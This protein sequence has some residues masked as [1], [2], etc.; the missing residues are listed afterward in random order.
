MSQMIQA[1]GSTFWCV[2]DACPR[3]AHCKRKGMCCRA[4]RRKDESP[5]E[6]YKRT[7]AVSNDY[8]RKHNG[9]Y[10]C[11]PAH[12][13]TTWLSKRNRDAHLDMAYGLL[14]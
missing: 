2:H 6:Y 13:R 9:R 10:Y 14:K 3:L 4:A 7:G 5:I 11:N 12:C 8:Q 1:G